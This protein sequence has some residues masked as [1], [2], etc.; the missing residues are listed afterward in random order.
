MLQVTL[1]SRTR[2]AVILALAAMLATVGL[3]SGSTA[4]AIHSTTITF[5]AGTCGSSN[6]PVSCTESQITFKSLFPFSSHLHLF[7]NRLRNHG[8]CCSHPYEITHA[9]GQKFTLVKMDVTSIFGS[10]TW[11]S[12]KGSQSVSGTGTHV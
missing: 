6:T 7:S 8:D 2:L 10:N 1:K 12:S 5:Q 9:G 11:S 3:V 4:S